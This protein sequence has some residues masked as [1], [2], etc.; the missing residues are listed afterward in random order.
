M[1]ITKVTSLTASH[2]FLLTSKPKNIDSNLLLE[3]SGIFKAWSL[4]N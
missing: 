4:Y 2:L 1:R 3:K